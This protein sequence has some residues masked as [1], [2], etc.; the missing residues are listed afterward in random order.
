MDGYV[1][2]GVDYAVVSV[3]KFVEFISKKGKKTAPD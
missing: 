2:G 1:C 3:D